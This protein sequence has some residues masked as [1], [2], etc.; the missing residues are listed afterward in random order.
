ML[1]AARKSPAAVGGSTLGVRRLPAVTWEADPVPRRDPSLGVLVETV[2]QGDLRGLTVLHVWKTVI[3][4]TVLGTGDSGLEVSA[5]LASVMS[6]SKHDLRWSMSR[7]AK[8][9]SNRCLLDP[10]S[11]HSYYLSL[12]S[13][14][15]ARLAVQAV[16]SDGPT[17][18][19]VSC[20]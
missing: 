4:V 18:G 9:L 5:V 12:E 13:W 17:R 2:G 7:T 11:G 15:C 10:L 1:L 16:R 19:G 8:G 14:D 3:S 6:Q 20:H